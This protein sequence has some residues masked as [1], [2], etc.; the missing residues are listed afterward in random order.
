M[1]CKRNLLCGEDTFHLSKEIMND[2]YTLQWIYPLYRQTVFCGAFRFSPILLPIIFSMDFR[3]EKVRHMGRYDFSS[4]ESF[5][6]TLGIN[7]TEH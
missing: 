5:L 1:H 2:V 4:D 3:R 7:T 6:P